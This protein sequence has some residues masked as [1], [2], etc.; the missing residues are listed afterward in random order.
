[1]NIS[2]N[3]DKMARYVRWREVDDRDVKSGRR[4]DEFMVKEAEV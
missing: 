3:I 2:L 4:C 1:M